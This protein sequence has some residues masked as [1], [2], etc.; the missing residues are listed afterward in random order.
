MKKYN[1]KILEKRIQKKWN[2]NNIF[3][4]DFE[5]KDKEKFYLLDMFPYPSGDGLHMG[6]TENYAITDTL[7]RFKKMAGFN[8]LHPQ[9]FDA[10]GLPAENYAI[11]TGIPPEETIK[12]TTTRFKEQIANLGL[13]HNF[14]N[15][16]VITSKPEYYK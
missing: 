16:A 6:H 2:E 11:K 12:K 4:T 8:V 1:H 10:F 7:Y 14:F 13:G 5:N 3:K 9:G 15:D